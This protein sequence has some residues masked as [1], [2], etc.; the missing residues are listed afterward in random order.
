[1]ASSTWIPSLLGSFFSAA[2]AGWSAIG[3]GDSACLV[4][5]GAVRASGIL[6]ASPSSYASSWR[7]GTVSHGLFRKGG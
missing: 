2:F 3:F 4:F 1:M 6:E 5:T 7:T